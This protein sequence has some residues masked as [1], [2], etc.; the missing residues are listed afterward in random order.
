MANYNATTSTDTNTQTTGADTLTVTNTNQIQSTDVFDGAAGTDSIIISGTSGVTVNL[1]AAATT[2]FK[3]YEG[4]TFDNT[5]GTSSATFNA[6]NFGTNLI[7]T[8][9]LIT[10]NTG[11]HQLYITGATSFTAA[12]W[13][14][15][16]WNSADLLSITGTSAADTITGSSQADTITG[17]AGADTMVGGLGADTFVISATTDLA[18][19]ETI[20]GT[21]ESG[22]LDTIRLD[23]AGTYNFSTFSTL[24]N[25][26]QIMVNSNAT[27][28][29]LTVN[30]SM[31]S[32]ADFS[33]DG[34]I[35]ELN[36]GAAVAM[37]NGITVSAAGLTGSNRIITD[38]TN[39]GGADT[40]TGGSGNDWL[41]G[42][43]GNDSLTGG[44]GNDVIN[45]GAGV[46]TLTGGTGSDTFV[47]TT[48]TD[49]AAGETINGT[50]E[51]AGLDTLRL[52]GAGT[53]N[54]STFTTITNIDQ[55]SL[56]NTSSSFTLTIADSQVSTADGNQDGTVGDLNITSAATSASN[57]INASALTG[58]NR[59]NLDGTY[60]SGSDTISGGA[61][62]DTIISGAG[63]DTV[64]G[65][66]GNDTI[67]GGAG[68]DNLTGG[69]GADTFVV[70]AVA[71]LAAGE[72]INGTL[73][74]ATL[75][76]IRL[77]AAGA[78][79]LSTFTTITNIDQITLNQNASGFSITVA[80][81]QVSTADGNVDGTV[82]DMLINSAVAMTNGV[83]I[84]GAGLT[85]TNRITVVGTNLGG[86]DTITGGAGA[87][88][89]A[90]GAGNDTI[91][92]GAGNDT[93]DGGT[94]DD[95][96]A[97]G[98]G[99]DS[100]TVDSASDVVTENASE[101]TDTVLASITYT[102]GSNV[103]N[104]TLTGSSAINGTGNALVNTITG[105]SAANTLD[106]GAGADTLV[107]GAGNDIYIVDNTG[108][109]V[110]ENASEGTDTVQSSATYTL[111]ANVENL[112]LT[113]AAA[114]NGTG[115]AL[116]NILTGN[117]AANTLDGGAG[118]D[119]MIGGLG[120]DIYVVDS[121]SDVVTEN[122]GEGTDT[123]QSA[124]TYALGVNLENLTLTGSS[125]INATGNA[126]NNIITGNSGDNVIDGGLGDDTMAGGAGNDTY[127][128]DSVN[129]V[130]TEAASAGTDTVNASI[131]Y[132]LGANI[133]NLVLSGTSVI[134]GTGN[135]SAN[136]ITGNSAANVIDGGTGA[137]TMIGGAGNDTYVVDNAGDV[138]T[139]NAS[140]GTDLVQSSVTYTLGTNVENLTLTGSTAI[141]GTGTALDNILIG[142]SAN[143]T[144]TGL[145]GNDTIDGGGGNDTMVGGTGDDTYV[146]DAAGD[147]V[148]E[149]A[150]E[151]TDT[152]QAAITY[153]LGANLENL[154]LT[155][156]NNINATGN[157]SANIIIGNAGENLIDGGTGADTMSGGL[158]NDTF[159][160][161]NS[162][163]VVTELASQ[164][165]DTVQS[166]ITYT[167]G[168]NI[169]NLTLTGSANINATGNSS[170][171]VITGNS[172]NNVIDGGTGADTMIGG[173]GD[174]TYF[175]DNAG[176]VVIE[177]AGGG[178]DTVQTVFS[179][180]LGGNI[181][182]LVLIGT[183]SINGTGD[184][185]NN[186]ITGNSGANVIDGGAGADT[187]TG[188]TG[189]DTYVID[190][191]GDV[192]NENAGEG[193]DTVIVNRTYTLLANFENLTL[194]G[195]DN[196][197]G[198]GTT[199]DNVII[200]NAGN[201]V[202]TGLAGNDTLDGGAG[203]D[204]L[205]GGT[206]D[207]IYVIDNV[208]DVAT[209][210]AGEGTDTIQTLF[211][212]T[213]GANFENLTLYGAA[214]INGTGNA[215]DNVITGNAAVNTLTGLAGNDTLNGGGGND[216]LIGGTGNDTYIIGNTGV[217]VTE[218][219]GEGTDR[220]MASISY[221]LGAN[222]ENLTLTGTGNIKGVGNTL[223][224][225]IVGNSGSNTLDGGAGADT[226]RGGIGSDVYV[227]DNVNDV[228]VEN[229]GQGTDTVQASVSYTLSAN[230]ENLTLTGTAGNTGTGNDL[231][232]ILTGNAGVNTLYG[233]GG[234]DSING[235]AGADIMYGGLG[236]DTYIVDNAGDIV[237]E[238]AAEGIDL[239]QSTVTYT[240]G[241]NV[242]NLLLTGSALVNGTGNELDNTLTGNAAN[243][244]LY[245]LDGNDTLNGARGADTMVGGLGNDYMYVDNTG[246]VVVENA[247]EGIDT[248]S[249]SIAYVLGANVE[250]LVLSGVSAISGSG[251]ELDN[252]ITGNSGANTLYGYGGNDTID[253]GRGSD[254]MVGGLGNDIYFVDAAGDSITELS[255][256]GTDTVNSTI[257]YTLGANLENL[258]LLGAG[259]IAGTGNTLDNV[260]T[261]NGG[262]NVLT[263]LAG[264]DIIDGGAGGDTMVGGIGDDTYY[265]DNVKD[266]V[267]E[268]T[269]E[270]TD[271]VYSSITYTLGTN[272]E[273]LTLTGTKAISAI[274]NA[275]NNILIGNDANNTLNGGAGIDTMT[276][277]GG[278][279]IYM[280][281]NAGDVVVEVANEGIDTVNSS[282]T[283]T[284]GSNLE[285]LTLTGTSAINGTGNELDN[286]LIGNSGNNTLIGGA[287]SDTLYGA[288]GNDIINGGAGLDFLQGGAGANTFVFSALTDSGTTIDTADEIQDWLTGN[289]IDLSAI[290]A[291]STVA[292]DQAFTIDTDGSFSAGEISLTQVGNDLVVSLNTNAD[293]NPEMVFIVNFVSS[294]SSSDFIL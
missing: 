144:L 101:G 36:I 96:M 88:S 222:I 270:G 252:L 71:D 265:V 244:A 185:G 105:N 118:N 10:G 172:G 66:A 143:N 176:D 293:S 181:E 14:F 3:N 74:T 57:T 9:A 107:G 147:V 229:A 175:V 233:L 258:T 8:T 234:N 124:V 7:S 37:T 170:D 184:S 60:M 239:V 135:A 49:L 93:I 198:T 264:N 282:I 218:Q 187:M 285:N 237:V 31:V 130:V 221:T 205:V 214:A 167:I 206:G 251:N 208:G 268:L 126:L 5:S 255:G 225:N 121:A 47:I 109:V 65:G 136:T 110:T 246:D 161:D 52:D 216:I 63:V 260:I 207:D 174:D 284:L 193:T 155:G 189:D 61:G 201:N 23:A 141:N 77:D 256:Q 134:N 95:T 266:V 253:G 4:I 91:T 50:S 217:T 227:V 111:S 81:S 262:T 194:S 231:L 203:A 274:G 226:M 146:V 139:E 271:T 87:D 19:G 191:V 78:Y 99:N 21:L 149:N 45:G 212:T 238:N 117:S 186:V 106:G 94:G 158:G 137:D 209:E 281:D 165:T 250:N 148:T 64:T 123:V 169:E 100:Y 232:N 162:G 67:N 16:S 6:S 248:V 276:G 197:N 168:V 11:L 190:N 129:D 114:I 90:G 247:N 73:E 283:Y 69:A 24:T 55:I 173:A 286:V 235:G 263:G 269:G 2:T 70:S 27:G 18:A 120:D 275:S 76:T 58:T 164:G 202:L 156:T 79:N 280:V 245:G 166:S 236:N 171:N 25:I 145:A 20:N 188:G 182:N 257:A 68:A 219:L 259:N 12:G 140:E 51:A 30:D 290:D 294:L 1:T 178:N 48:S 291:N 46:D 89:L 183:D 62:A 195:T 38:G 204:T 241:A 179:F 53:Y 32:T 116:A 142:N 228:V 160:V 131:S 192:V 128:V 75:D 54:L 34:I 15:S 17:G 211:T 196:I 26:D 180:T 213:L 39:L 59:I 287:G 151:G 240:L 112:T 125:A 44:A 199:G 82:G 152:V 133:E 278:D 249:S 138:V 115:N 224:N 177:S 200:G 215:S 86:A 242:E 267:T 119:T 254:V 220:V 43:A 108:D 163:D 41:N 83:T 223:D 97:G 277:H 292:G 210:N 98:A 261:G 279:D 42:G 92:G 154:T 35:G 29:V 127:Y 104:L 288:D 33:Q 153:T 22:T 84:S 56:N 289:K 40:M 157:A 122:A 273:N 80:D 150:G 102:L 13:T 159:I 230:V 28:F 103:E 272:L 132:N 113:G 72:T 85:G 243:N